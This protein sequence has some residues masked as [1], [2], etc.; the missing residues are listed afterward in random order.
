MIYC[1]S[2]APPRFHCYR[3]RRRAIS[4]RSNAVVSNRSLDLA[5]ILTTSS[6]AMLAV[7]AIVNVIAVEVETETAGCQFQIAARSRQC[8]RLLRIAIH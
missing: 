7:A 6:S 2:V 3:Y 1:R 4:I 8:L 5:C